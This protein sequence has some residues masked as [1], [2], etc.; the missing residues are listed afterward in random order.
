[1][2]AVV[3]TASRNLYPH[4]IYSLRSLFRNGNVDKVYFIIEDD[5]L[6]FEV[7]DSEIINVGDSY[8]NIFP[9][10][11]PNAKV[12]FTRMVLMRTL[13]ARLLPKDLDTVLQLDVDTIICDDLSP[14][15]DIDMRGK[16]FAAVQEFKGSHRPYGEKYYNVGVSLWNLKQIREDGMDYTVVNALNTEHFLYGEQCAWNKYALPNLRI[17]DMP[18]RFNETPFTGFTDNPAVVHYAGTKNWYESPPF[19]IRREYLDKYRQKGDVL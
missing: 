5:H 9:D 7:P 11:S 8:R 3:Y 10:G 12:M 17:A 6:P 16:Y 15:W 1:M 14:L 19:M 13:T 2:K 18:L 4:M